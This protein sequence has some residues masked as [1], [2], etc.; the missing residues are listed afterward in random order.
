MHPGITNHTWY[1]S[2]LKPMLKVIMNCN[3]IMSTTSQLH[4]FCSYIDPM[5]LVIVDVWFHQ[6][7]EINMLSH[8]KRVTDTWQ[9]SNRKQTFKTV[10]NLDPYH[11]VQNTPAFQQHTRGNEHP[12]V[13]GA[14]AGTYHSV[15]PG[16]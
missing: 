14:V 2:V 16:D 8:F 15:C 13:E 5:A 1:Y 6:K 12:S 3:F 4:P 11:K 10:Q 7:T 9:K